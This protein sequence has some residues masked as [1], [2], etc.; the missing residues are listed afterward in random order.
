MS[1]PTSGPLPGQVIALLWWAVFVGVIAHQ[2]VAA[3]KDRP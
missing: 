2:Y 1:P 3:R